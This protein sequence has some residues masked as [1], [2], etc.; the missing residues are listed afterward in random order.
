MTALMASLPT[1]LD[2][3]TL[4]DAPL[5]TRIS[6]DAEERLLRFTGIL[7]LDEKKALD[8]LSN[9]PNYLNAVNS[10]ALQP[11]A[12]VPPDKRIWLTLDT[13]LL[14]PLRSLNVAANDNLAKNLVIVIKKALTYL[15]E[16]LSE[17][18]VIQQGG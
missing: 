5:R 18:A 13:D 9:D 4:A 12:I 16:A 14:F 11:N 7:S 6:Y 17:S 3:S 8:E 1:P 10:V 15:H 2:F